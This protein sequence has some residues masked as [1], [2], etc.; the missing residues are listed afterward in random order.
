MKYGCN[1]T[2]LTY[3]NEV[4][5]VILNII[6]NA[7]DAFLERNIDD[8]VIEISTYIEKSYLC[9]SVKDNAAL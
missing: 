3:K 8:G 4:L 5:Q 6:K 9:L 7:Q 2:L 1:Q